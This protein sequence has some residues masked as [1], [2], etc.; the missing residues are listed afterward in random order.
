M[1]IYQILRQTKYLI[2]SQVWSGSS[3]VVFHPDSII[4]V[5]QDSE[6]DALDQRP[7]IPICL[8][9]PLD[10]Q[11]DPQ[12]GE[13]P[14]LIQRQ[15]AIALISENY[16][17]PLGQGALI[18]ANRTGATDSRGRGVLEL[19]PTLAAI[20]K[21]VVVN[22]VLIS[23]KEQG[24]PA[25]KKDPEDSS[26]AIQ[27]FN[28][29]AWCTSQAT[30]QAPRKLATRPRTG[31]VDL[32]WQ[33]PPDRFDRY[34]VVLRR[35]AGSTPPAT[36][37]DGTGVTLSGNLATSVSDTGLAVGTYSYSLFAT[38]D[39]FSATPATDLWASDPVTVTVTAF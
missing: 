33:V 24:I 12:H 7:I 9:S 36:I 17:D 35:A 14:D 21:L 4:I 3:T 18:G 11:S 34:R 5:A 38:Y 26:Y 1:N 32:T 16:G 15:I 6:I 39:D 20:K 10:G 8:I 28:F 37:T 19:E 23:L 29:E 27:A 2:Q 22:G 30:Y 31:Q 25:A 13:E